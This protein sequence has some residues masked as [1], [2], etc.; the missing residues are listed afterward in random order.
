MQEPRL[1]T[2]KPVDGDFAP[3][4]PH[5]KPLPDHHIWLNCRENDP[6]EDHRRASSASHAACDVRDRPVM[7]VFPLIVSHAS[8]CPCVP[9]S[10]IGAGRTHDRNVAEPGSL[11][12]MKPWADNMNRSS[13]SK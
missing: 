2:L 10:R 3:H 11:S 6:G 13:P 5:R 8:F 9:V 1:S 12:T 4:A 7:I